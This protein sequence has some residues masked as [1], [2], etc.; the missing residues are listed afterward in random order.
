[1]DILVQFDNFYCR[2]SLLYY[3]NQ[4]IR[5]KLRIMKYKNFQGGEIQVVMKVVSCVKRY[6]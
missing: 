4:K 2:T 3:K 5:K 6:K 1:M